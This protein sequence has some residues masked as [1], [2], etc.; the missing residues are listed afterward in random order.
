MSLILD[1]LKRA[2]R[3]RKAEQSHALTDLPPVPAVSPGRRWVWRLAGLALLLIVI[4][5][6]AWTL[7]RD[8]PTP[9]PE[10]EPAIEIPAEVPAP[11]PEPEPAP[12]PTPPPQADPEVIPGTEGLASLDD[13][14]SEPAKPAPA[15]PTQPV[16]P[17]QPGTTEIEPAQPEQPAQDEASEPQTNPAVPPVLTQRAPLRKFREMPPEYR[18]DFPALRIDV[19]VY[20]QA[21]P[22][23]FVIVND[24]RY[25]EGEQLA[26][27]P[28]LREIVREGMVL[29]YRGEKLVYTLSR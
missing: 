26:E 17:R 22:R 25:R 24:R 5:G 21:P 18:A 19:H 20:E 9:E 10:S 11:E 13:L 29:E 4:A 3:E 1:A 28:V 14:T 15:L 6:L 16:K 23:R 12:L 8:P 27:G 2:E 7:L